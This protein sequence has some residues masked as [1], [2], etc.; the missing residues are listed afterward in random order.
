[1]L[2]GNH[3]TEKQHTNFCSDNS[4]AGNPSGWTCFFL[5]VCFLA[6]LRCSDVSACQQLPLVGIPWTLFS[7]DSTVR[8]NANILE[9]WKSPQITSKPHSLFHKKH[10]CHQPAKSGIIDVSVKDN[11]LL[12]GWSSYW[13][14]QWASV[15]DI[16]HHHHH[17]VSC[18]HSCHDT[19]TLWTVVVI[20]G[21][22][23][24]IMWKVWKKG[25][26]PLLLHEVFRM[27]G[28]CGSVFFKPFRFLEHV[29]FYL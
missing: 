22:I 11:S 4:K 9:A 2:F 14:N 5:F 18:W 13:R 21:D 23:M 7:W 16:W 6:M 20:E 26:L 8:Y 25:F 19:A 1:M 12:I 29:L 17:Q 3:L 28:V 15:S 24:E 27:G 10:D